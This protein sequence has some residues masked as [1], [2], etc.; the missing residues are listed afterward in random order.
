MRFWLCLSALAALGCVGISP[1]LVS[2][3]DIWTN[4]PLRSIG[5]L[6]VAAGIV[7][8]LRV[9]RHLGWELRGSW[10]GLFPLAFAFLIGG[11]QT[12][13]SWF[14]VL[15]TVHFNFIPPKLALYCLGSGLVILFAGWRLW[16]KAWFP[17]L[18]FFFSQPVPL[19]SS[20]SLDLP[21]QILSAHVAR[22]FAVRIGFAPTDPELLRLMFTPDFGMFIAPGCDGMR[23]AVA[24]GYAA[25]I[26]GYLKRVSIRRWA[27]Y[28]AGA[29]FLGYFFN[30]VRLCALVLYYRIAVGH[31]WL[32]NVAKEA[33]YAIGGALILFAAILLAWALTRTNGKAD[34]SIAPQPPGSASTALSPQSAVFRLTAFALF[35]LVSLVPGVLAL[36]HHQKSIAASVT[37]GDLPRAQLDAMMP[38]QIGAYKLARTWQEDED[39]NVKVE[40]AAYSGPTADEVVLGVWL[41]PTQHNMHDSWAV[42]GEAPRM[43]R[44]IGFP[45]ANGSQV[46][47]DSAFYSDGI[48]DSFAGNVFCSPRS[49]T[50]AP[51]VGQPHIEFV[52]NPVDFAT[53]GTRAVS[54]FFRVDAPHSDTQPDQVRQQLT[55]EAREFVAGID[56][57]AMS[58]KFQ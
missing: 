39:G 57:A 30:L 56:F 22:A 54:M 48:I 50:L 1:A 38:R 41:P 19:V 7:L 47:F 33:D 40:S 34:A 6:I 14:L 9:W 15:G 44:D 4:D 26:V 23:G 8:T 55:E 35:V 53:R 43:R 42:R 5:I 13:L 11:L 52:V 37:D 2:L 24:M 16:R 27:A 46:L 51:R 32:E 49:C 58:R 36:L 25:L 21:L 31:P 18:L 10:W 20:R 45:T 28:V 29:V 17:L 12:K 3:W